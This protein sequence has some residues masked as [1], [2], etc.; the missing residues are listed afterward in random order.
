[1]ESYNGTN[2]NKTAWITRGSLNGESDAIGGNEPADSDMTE[3]KGP[4]DLPGPIGLRMP[5]SFMG[6]RGPIGVTGQ[7]GK[8]G[9]QGL[10]GPKGPAGA[11]GPQGPAGSF[12]QRLTCNGKTCQVIA[13]LHPVIYGVNTSYEGSHIG[14][15]ADTSIFSLTGGHTYFVEVSVSGAMLSHPDMLIAVQLNEVSVN[16]L[17]CVGHGKHTTVTGYVYVT[18]P[19]GAA[20]TLQ[21]VNVSGADIDSADSSIHIAEVE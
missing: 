2:I 20:G 14:H 5:Q 4:A 16:T 12:T 3:Q 1:M 6:P 7:M 19:P 18:V 13:N 9:P 10:T 15:S 11:T 21:I 17:H 8:R